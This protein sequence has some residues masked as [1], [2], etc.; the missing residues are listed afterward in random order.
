MREDPLVMPIQ[1]LVERASEFDGKA[2][3]RVQYYSKT[4]EPFFSM[5]NSID[6][7]KTPTEVFTEELYCDLIS[8]TSRE[9]AHSFLTQHPFLR[10]AYH[11]QPDVPGMQMGEYE[12]V[13]SYCDF[14]VRAVEQH[15]DFRRY[16]VL[17]QRETLAPSPEWHE[18]MLQIYKKYFPILGTKSASYRTLPEMRN[19]LFE[20]YGKVDEVVEKMMELGSDSGYTYEELEE[21]YFEG[22]EDLR[23]AHYEKLVKQVDSIIDAQMYEDMARFIDQVNTAA[24][25][26]Y[27]AAELTLQC[28]CSTLL[29]AMYMMLFVAIHNQD[30][31][32]ICS[33]P[34]CHKYYKVD[35]RYPQ[36]LC[37]DHMASRRRKRQNQRKYKGDSFYAKSPGEKG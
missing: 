36:T 18:E 1:I 10:F 27:D 25:I 14:M 4:G 13:D 12:T 28:R 34:R 29:P 30:E 11:R 5:T 9:E 8:I 15:N 19:H 33:N 3:G 26:S 20:Q 17:L 31:Y 23:Q 24:T 6:D 35:K 7:P 22:H 16:E 32:R 37:D 2:D 21:E